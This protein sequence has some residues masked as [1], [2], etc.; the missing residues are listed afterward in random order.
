MHLPRKC[1]CLSSSCCNFC[2]SRN[3]SNYDIAS[4]QLQCIIYALIKVLTVIQLSQQ[5]HQA[6]N[7]LYSPHSHRHTHAHTIKYEFLKALSHK[8][9]TEVVAFA[10]LICH[11]LSTSSLYM[12]VYMCVYVCVYVVVCA[13]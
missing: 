3:C 11:L 12:D 2:V 10:Q 13:F 6:D 7:P 8:A 5:Q 9:A 1:C 4:R